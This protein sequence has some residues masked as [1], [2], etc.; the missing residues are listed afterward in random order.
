MDIAA[1]EIEQYAVEHTSAEPAWF[2]PLAQRTRAETSAP[3]MMV[4]TLEGRFL[5]AL[6]AAMRPRLVLELG[7]FTGYS[8]LSMAE[9]LPSGGR[10]ITCDISEEHVAMA[11][12][13]IATSPFADRIEIMVGPAL[14]SVE[15]LDGPFDLVFIDADKENYLRYYEAVLPKLAPDGLIAVDNVLWSGRVL[16]GGDDDASTAA[17]REFNDRL[18]ADERVEVVMLTVRDG[19]SLVRRRRPAPGD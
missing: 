9:T 18:A 1:A 14:D 16:P 13:N 6:V 12:R 15:A 17:I 4:G 5:A 11:R 19:L 3:S 8:A 7:T 2:G 10:I